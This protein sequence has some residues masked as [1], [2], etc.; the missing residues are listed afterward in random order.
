MDFVLIAGLWLDGGEAWAQVIEEL[1]RLGH[2][3]L[4]V[5]LPGQ[6][7]GRTDATL[8]QQ[9][10]AVLAAVDAAENPVV[11]GHSAACALA[12]IAADA[13]PEKVGPVV[14]VG[15]FPNRDGQVYGPDF[16]IRD[17]AMAF[18]GW[19]PFEGPDAVDLDEDLRRTMAAR[20]IPVPE[21]VVRGVVRLTDERRYA[22]RTVLVCPEYS[23]EQAKRWIESGELPE[24]EKTERVEYIDI[25]S[26]H[27]PMYTRPAEL[28]RILHET[29]TS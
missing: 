13:R 3:A 29:A 17:G 4:P 19:E 18:P 16:E 8:E 1:E 22:L 25:D 27:W 10:Q 26:G 2:R 14:L 23:P 21:G 20:A 28:A 24:L 11:V 15:G 9:A 7:D 5:R 12:W 6:G